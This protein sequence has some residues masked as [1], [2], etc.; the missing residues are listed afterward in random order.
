MYCRT[1]RELA[2][3]KAK[4]Q[5]QLYRADYYGST[6]IKGRDRANKWLKA[7]LPE[8][9][10]YKIIEKEMYGQRA[11][12]LIDNCGNVGAWGY[13]IKDC[14][15]NTCKRLSLRVPTLE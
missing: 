15:I 13:N 1:D 9:Q 8:W 3:E 2:K 14:V 12:A 10:D 6:P 11:Y 5:K 4:V 7:T